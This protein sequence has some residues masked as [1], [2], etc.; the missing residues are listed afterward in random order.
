MTPAAEGGKSMHELYLECEEAAEWEPFRTKSAYIRAL[1]GGTCL[2]YQVYTA[3]EISYLQ[4]LLASRRPL[5]HEQHLQSARS[6]AASSLPGG[7]MAQNEK[8]IFL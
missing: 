2:M 5:V 4:V 7:F 6:P 3:A 1:T 8:R